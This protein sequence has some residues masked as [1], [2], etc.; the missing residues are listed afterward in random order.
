M[1]AEFVEKMVAA[2]RLE[3]QAF[4]LLVPEGLRDAAALAVRVCSAA[5]L[6]VLDA[7]NSPHEGESDAPWA[8]ACGNGGQVRSS[9]K[10]K[11]VRNASTSHGART[12][13]LQSIV[14][15]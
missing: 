9:S 7:S 13:G 4:A 12:S 6:D 5:A 14:I 8:G 3:A 2:K 10:A 1:N 15:E 11:G